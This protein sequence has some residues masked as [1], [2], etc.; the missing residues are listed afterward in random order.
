MSPSEAEEQAERRRVMLQDA[1]VRKQQQATST[2]LTIC[3][4]AKSKRR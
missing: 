2:Y 1:D 4:K 3:L